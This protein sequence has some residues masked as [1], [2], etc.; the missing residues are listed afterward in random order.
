MC[1]NAPFERF[2][3]LHW[4]RYLDR[5][6]SDNDLYYVQLVFRGHNGAIA[7]YAC[8]SG[9]SISQKKRTQ[10]V[11]HKDSE[12]GKNRIRDNSVVKSYVQIDL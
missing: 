3:C 10:N 5:S 7:L 11:L 1:G 8:V 12:N 9:V 6:I 4:K 2:G